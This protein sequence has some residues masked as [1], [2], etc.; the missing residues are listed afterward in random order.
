MTFINNLQKMPT[1]NQQHIHLIFRNFVCNIFPFIIL[2][3][4]VLIFFA[5]Y[6]MYTKNTNANIAVSILCSLLA[7]FV[8]LL[9]IFL[10]YQAEITRNQQTSYVDKYQS[11]LNT[12]IP[13]TDSNSLLLENRHD[14]ASG[15]SGI[16]I[17]YHL[18]HTNQKMAIATIVNKK[19]QALTPQG[20][21]YKQLMDKLFSITNGKKYFFV[22][23]SNT[24]ND[25]L[26]LKFMYQNKIYR[27]S[28]N[29]NHLITRESN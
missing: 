15:Q 9:F 25:N 6:I 1:P 19:Y 7:M 4:V 23:I 16:T 2:S 26:K 22:K 21:Q 28:F 20:K 12:I 14:D 13:G 3:L 8:M 5:T 27:L 10:T 11:T 18:N 29:H 17:Y 24:S